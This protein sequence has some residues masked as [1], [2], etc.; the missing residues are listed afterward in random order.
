LTRAALIAAAAALV[1]LAALPAPG[2]A[3]EPQMEDA[4]LVSLFA[5][6]CTR[7]GVNAEAILAGVTGSSD[8]SEVAAP[9]VNLRGLEQVPSRLMGSALRRPEWV[10]QWQRT[11]NGRELTL[12][13][14]KMSDRNVYHHVCALF[15]PDIRYGW[16]YFDAFEAAM[17][18]ISLSG[19][20]NDL[21]HYTEYGGRLADRRRAHADLFGR[22]RAMATPRTMHMAIV[23]E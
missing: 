5:E 2:A 14:A 15:A 13:I 4:S 9:T 18:G 11:V 19:K 17:E 6:T 23:Y 10:R 22:S 8:W 12:V 16:P 21:P 7:G 3:A 20:S 1:S